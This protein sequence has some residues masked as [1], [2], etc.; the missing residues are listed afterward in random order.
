MNAQPVT[1][2]KMSI[3]KVNRN[4]LGP[5]TKRDFYSVLN[6]HGL[7]PLLGSCFHDGRLLC[8]LLPESYCAS[9]LVP[10]LK[11]PNNCAVDKR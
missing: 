10:R 5:M 9:M 6:M 11:A 7:V 4:S 1:Q 8:N 3:F 2:R